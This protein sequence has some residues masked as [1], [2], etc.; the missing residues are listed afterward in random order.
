MTRYPK[1]ILELMEQFRRLPGVGPKTALRFVFAALRWTDADRDALARALRDVS[2]QTTRCETCMNVAESD[3]CRLCSDPA[4]DGS[5]ICV[6]AEPQ[7]L[8]AIEA[9]GA[10]RGRYHVLG[11]VLSPLDGI[12]PDRLAITRL[13]TR[14]KTAQPHPVLEVVLAL[15]PSIEGETTMLYLARR[16]APLGVK[17]TRL[18]RGLPVGADL[19][20]ADEVTLGDALRG[21]RSVTAA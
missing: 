18:A 1:A 21:R 7:H 9:T 8:A 14:I 20:Y 16:L 6:V 5:V 11:G 19:E 10:Y 3:P 4:R 15:E 17:V 12:T 13:E 2:A